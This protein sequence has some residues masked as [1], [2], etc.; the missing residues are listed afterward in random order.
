MS[1]HNICLIFTCRFAAFQLKSTSFSV[2][3]VP[4]MTVVNLHHTLTLKLL[5]LPSTTLN[6]RLP[7]FDGDTRNYP[8]TSSST[9]SMNSFNINFNPQ[10][11]K[12]PSKIYNNNN[13]FVNTLT[14]TSVP[15]TYEEPIYVNNFDDNYKFPYTKNPFFNGNTQ[16]L[17]PSQP[18]EVPPEPASPPPAPTFNYYGNNNNRQPYRKVCGRLGGNGLV[19]NGD[20]VLPGSY[21]WLVAIYRTT[22]IG[23][24]FTC[25][26]TLISDRHVV[27]GKRNLSPGP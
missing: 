5:N 3:S 14:S 9:T 26:G 10:P 13:G 12:D 17:L 27:S 6:T 11:P 7:I 15:L 2:K 8:T 19:V 23:L 20:R 25:G 16:V 1:P 22:S 4:I 21:P 24:E 18:S